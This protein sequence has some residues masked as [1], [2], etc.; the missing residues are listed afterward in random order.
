[1]K[2]W[3]QS[4]VFQTGKVFLALGTYCNVLLGVRLHLKTKPDF[5]LVFLLLHWFT[6]QNSLLRPSAL[7]AFPHLVFSLSSSSCAEVSDKG[8]MLK[9]TQAPFSTGSV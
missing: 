3:Q 4:P 6:V 1:M 9:V 8:E 5:L 7:L 2:L